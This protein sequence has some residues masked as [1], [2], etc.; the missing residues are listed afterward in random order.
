MR[1]GSSVGK[2][3]NCVV[4]DRVLFPTQA[5][6]LFTYTTRTMK[7]PIEQAVYRVKGTELEASH[8]LTLIAEV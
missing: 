6:L 7:S 8:P 1:R 4:N 2:S 3:T 5:F